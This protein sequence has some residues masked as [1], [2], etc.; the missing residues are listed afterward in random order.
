MRALGHPSRHLGRVAV[1]H[2]ALKHRERQAVDLQE[3][4]AGHVG[5]RTVAGAAGDALDHAQRVGVIVVRAEE[6][7]EH[8][9][10]CG[11]DDSGGQSRPERVDFER[12][13]GDVRRQLEDPRVEK[14]DE[15]EASDEHEGQPQRRDQ[16]RQERVEQR[17]EGGREKRSQQTLHVYARQEPRRRIDGQRRRHP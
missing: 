12:V 7:F 10:H 9:A 1:A 5:D 2:G 11:N 15:K 8:H 3:E 14:Q 16:W 6:D 17:D 4:D 13:I